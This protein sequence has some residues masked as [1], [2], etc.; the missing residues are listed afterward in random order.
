MQ[1]G[2]ALHRRQT[3]RH[4]HVDDPLHA[5]HVDHHAVGAGA[6]SERMPGADGAH[7][8]AALRSLDDDLRQLGF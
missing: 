3:G 7:P 8:F 4:I 6:V 2:P 1:P 5:G